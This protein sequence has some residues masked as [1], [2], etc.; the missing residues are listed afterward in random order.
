MLTHINTSISGEVVSI[1]NV[2]L[3][4]MGL[5]TIG[6]PT[7]AAA[8]ESEQMREVVRRRSSVAES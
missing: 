1:S 7:K 5:R 3:G 4:R 2:L 8:D 6:G